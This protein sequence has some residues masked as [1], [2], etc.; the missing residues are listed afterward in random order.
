MAA[1]RSRRSCRCAAMA[2]VCAAVAM[3]GNGS[4][5]CRAD[6][7]GLRGWHA[8]LGGEARYTGEAVVE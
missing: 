2:A 6:A 7:R 4:S 3:W 8:C 1:V 5:S